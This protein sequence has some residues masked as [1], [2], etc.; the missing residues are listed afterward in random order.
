MAVS[1]FLFK[2]FTK[3]AH[4]CFMFGIFGHIN[5]PIAMGPVHVHRIKAAQ[6]ARGQLRPN[7]VL[8]YDSHPCT[9]DSGVNH[10]VQGTESYTGLGVDVAEMVMFNPALPDRQSLLTIENVQQSL[11][12]EGWGHIF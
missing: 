12:A 3:Q 5:E 6:Y 9:T 1:N 2:P 4:H 8:V 10:L 7:H 11:G